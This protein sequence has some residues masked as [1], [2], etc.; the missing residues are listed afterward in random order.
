MSNIYVNGKKTNEKD[1]YICLSS[2]SAFIIMQ[3]SD[4]K[5]YRKRGRERVKKEEEEKNVL[6]KSKSHFTNWTFGVIFI[7]VMKIFISKK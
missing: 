3:L 5:I 1:F 6:Q 2:V 7:F 4:I